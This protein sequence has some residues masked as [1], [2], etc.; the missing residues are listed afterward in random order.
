MCKSVDR[1]ASGTEVYDFEGVALGFDHA[2]LRLDVAVAEAV[3]VD[4]AHAGQQLRSGSASAEISESASEQAT[5]CF[6]AA[7]RACLKYLRASGSGRR[8]G[9]RSLITSSRSFPLTS[10][11]CATA[12]QT[13]AHVRQRI[14]QHMTRR[15]QA[16]RVQHKRPHAPRTT[17]TR[18]SLSGEE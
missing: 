7:L 8:L 17:M 6:C 9:S 18:R 14:R 1:G 5:R 16:L 12:Q 2:V 15:K 3:V 13:D 10:S 11:H 4:V